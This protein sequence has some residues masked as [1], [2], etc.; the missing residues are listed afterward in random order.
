MRPPEHS[1]LVEELARDPSSRKRFLKGVGGTAAA[2]SFGAFLTA[3]GSKKQNQVT[4]GGS[5][6]NTAAGVGTDQYGKGDLGI[7]IFALRLEYVESEF[8]AKALATGK[9]SGKS[10]TLIQRFGAQENAHVAT[11]EGIVKGL[12]GK[13]PQKPSTTFPLSTPNQ[14]LQ[15]AANLEYVGAGAYLGQADRIQSKQLLAAALS[16]HTVEARHNAAI[17]LM[18]GHD[19][20]PDG[21]FA[22]PQFAIDVNQ[23]VEQFITVS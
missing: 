10:K 16:I 8:C 20:S 13:L 14:I 4:P 3:C 23:S 7:A 21:A 22:K 15:T 6:R 19:I 12:G 5:N 17:N 1:S 9:L 11:L 2:A 18:L